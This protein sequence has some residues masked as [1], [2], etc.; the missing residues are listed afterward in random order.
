MNGRHAVT[1]AVVAVAIAVTGCSGK[2][3]GTTDRVAPQSSVGS[4]VAENVP[5]SP[6]AAS[7]S[8]EQGFS[9]RPAAASATAA[10]RGQTVT[11]AFETR[12]GTTCQLLFTG[13]EEQPAAPFPA[14]VA[15]SA[16]RIAWSWHVASSLA[17]GPITARVACSGGAVGQLQMTVT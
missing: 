16:G 10:P 7:P 13:H 9:L 17:P 3:G 11:V 5:A 15:N 2:N 14:A 4:V 1:G 8:P 12:P 6:A